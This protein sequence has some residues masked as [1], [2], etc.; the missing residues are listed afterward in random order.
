MALS[1]IMRDMETKFKKMQSN[2]VIFANRPAKNIFV[3]HFE[4]TQN[5]LKP[6]KECNCNE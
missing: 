4:V 3:N 1:V 6:Q 5:K 2:W